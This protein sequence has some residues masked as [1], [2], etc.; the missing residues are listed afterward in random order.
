M[1]SGVLI[2]DDNAPFRASARALLQVEGL[3][4]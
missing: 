1:R 2:V 4:S 3:T